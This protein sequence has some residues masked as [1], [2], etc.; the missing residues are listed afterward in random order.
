[1]WKPLI[2]AAILAMAPLSAGAVTIDFTNNSGGSVSQ[3]FGDLPGKV[4]VTYDYSFNNGTSWTLGGQLWGNGYPGGSSAGPG[5][6]ALIAPGGNP[7]VMRVTLDA[8][9][10]NLIRSYGVVA[11][12]YFPSSNG[13]T[14][15]GLINLIVNPTGTPGAWTKVVFEL[16]PDWDYGYN[17]IS[18]TIP[19]PPA[20][21][22][23]GAGLLGLGYL[24][25]SRKASKVA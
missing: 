25:R 20:A 7:S 15:P 3:S 12:T 23:L 24:S 19:L 5:T 1:M 14:N 8:I 4:N 11:N 18:Y 22:L 10:A 17:S 6:G 21:L 16:R 9:G 13:A 2:S